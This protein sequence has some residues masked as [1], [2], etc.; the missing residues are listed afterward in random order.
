M[1]WKSIEATSNTSTLPTSSHLLCKRLGNAVKDDRCALM[2]LLEIINT[3]HPVTIYISLVPI[4]FWFSGIVTH[5]VQ[6]EFLNI[7]VNK[8][9]N[10]IDVFDFKGLGILLDG[11]KNA[12][13]K[14][15]S[16]LI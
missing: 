2:Q 8:C 12:G 1:L 5:P 14:C 9:I 15:L 7:L 6:L 3:T 10:S 4:F 16:V 13:K 11:A